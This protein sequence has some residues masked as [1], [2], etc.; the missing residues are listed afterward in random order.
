MATE[1]VSRTEATAQE[2]L[3]LAVETSLDYKSQEVCLAL[4]RGVLI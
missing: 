1:T 2:K 4:F 3:Q